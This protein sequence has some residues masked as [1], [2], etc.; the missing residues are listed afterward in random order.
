M[1]TDSER[2]TS[3]FGGRGERDRLFMMGAVEPSLEKAIEPFEYETDGDKGAGLGFLLEGCE[4][5]TTE[6]RL[7]H[8]ARRLETCEMGSRIAMSCIPGL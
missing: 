5:E 6:S 4:L 3:L 8:D 2:F 1:R 7:I